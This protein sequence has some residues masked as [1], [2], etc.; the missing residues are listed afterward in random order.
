MNVSSKVINESN[1]ESNEKENTSVANASI[2]SQRDQ[3]EFSRKVINKISRFRKN[4]IFDGMKFDSP[5]AKMTWYKMVELNSKHKDNKRIDYLVE[6]S[7]SS[8][9]SKSSVSSISNDLIKENNG[10]LSRLTGRIKSGV[11]N[12]YRTYE[13]L[14]K[15]ERK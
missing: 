10:A 12:G 3:E 6:K 15:T 9:S 4:S 7:M 2:I 14:Q 1:Q 5:R 13:Q 11:K 8:L